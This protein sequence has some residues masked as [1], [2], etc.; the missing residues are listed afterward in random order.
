[1]NLE[2]DEVTAT[3][4]RGVP[5]EIGARCVYGAPAGRSIDLVE[6]EVTGF[7]PSGRVWVRIIRRRWSHAASW[8]TKP[9]A[10]VG[11]DRLTI[12]DA[13]PESPLPTEDD[14]RAAREAR[15]ACN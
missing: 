1:V 2:G 7:T 10:H 9:L 15:R 3:D 6:A 14:H 4:A 13:L 5:I 11:A 12:V 8:D